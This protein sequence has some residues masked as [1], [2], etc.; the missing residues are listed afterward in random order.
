MPAAG[1]GRVGAGLAARGHVVV[2]VDADPE[3]IEAAKADYPGPTWLVADLAELDL[4]AHGEPEPFDAVVCAGN[5]MP[6][7]APGTEGEVLRRIATHLRDDGLFVV[8]F[9]LD[10]G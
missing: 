10:R 4:A 9:G 3:L 6:F 7:L 5:V 2:G 1:P 8:G